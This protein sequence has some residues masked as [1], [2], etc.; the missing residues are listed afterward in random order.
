VTLQLRGIISLRKSLFEVTGKQKDEPFTKS[1]IS[2]VNN[3][4]SSDRFR[5]HL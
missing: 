4:A 3:A 1:M 2:I 5:V